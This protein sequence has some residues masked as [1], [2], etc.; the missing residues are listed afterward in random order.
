MTDQNSTMLPRILDV[1]CGV[2]GSLMCEQGEHI[3][4]F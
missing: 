2:G 1:T 4:S 3:D